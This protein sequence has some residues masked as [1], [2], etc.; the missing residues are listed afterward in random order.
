MNPKKLSLYAGLVVVGILLL[1]LGSGLRLYTDWLWFDAIGYSSV[2]FTILLSNLWLQVSVGLVAFA[3]LA[4]N[5]LLTRKT[6][7]QKAQVFLQQENVVLIEGMELPW[8]KL[9]TK[10]IL[11]WGAIA[12]SALIAFLLSLTVSSEWELLQKFLNPNSFGLADPL[13]SRDVGFY[14]FTFPFQLFLYNTIFWIGLVTTLFVGAAYYLS[15][16]YRGFQA[17]FGESFPRLHVGGL[18]T[19]LLLVKAWGYYLERHLL[20]YSERGAVFGAGW[21]DVNASLLAY[22]VL[23]VLALLAAGLIIAAA[24]TRRLQPNIL[25]YAVGGIIVA[26]IALSVVYPAVLQRFAVDPNE[27][28]RERPFL[29]ENIKFTREAYGIND[30]ERQP[31]PAGQTVDRDVI[32]ANNP[33]VDNIRLWDWEALRSSYAQLQ[34]IRTYYEFRDIDIDRYTIDG[35]Y[36]QVMLAPRELDQTQLPDQA[37]TWVNQRLVYTH[38][39]GVAMSPANEVSQEGQPL[40]LMQDIPAQVASEELRLDQ[41][42]IYFGEATDPY[43]IAPS[44]QPEFNYPRGEDN[45]F[46]NYTGGTGVKLDSWLKRI[47]FAITKADYNLLLSGD[48]TSESEL[49]MDRNIW[50]RVPKIAP[51][52]QLDDDPYVVVKDGKLYWIWDAYTTSNMFPYS[53]PAVRGGVNY[54]RNSVKVV[55]DAYTGEVEFYVSEP[56]DP[57]IQTYQ[58][59]FPEMFK[60]LDQMPQGLLEHIRYPV[61]L[62]K[63]QARIYTSYH[64][65]NPDVFYSREDQWR[66]PNEISGQEERPMEPYYVIMQ[67]PDNE[68]S[69]FVQIMPFT[70][71]GRAN[72]IGWMAG[73]SDGDNYGNLVVFEMPKDSLVYGPMQVEARVDQDEFISQQLTLWERRGSSVIRGNLLVIP[74]EDSLL[75]VEPVYLQA[76]QS[77]MPEL[78]RVILVHGDRVV[79]EPDLPSALNAMFGESGA[80]TDAPPPVPDMDPGDLDDLDLPDAPVVDQTTA[81]LIEE[82][83]LEYERAQQRLRDGDWTGYGQAIEALG[84]KLE[85]LARQSDN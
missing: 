34:Q 67:L 70:P 60:D 68:E 6:I 66:L 13:F 33:T 22:N 8:K 82:A 57:I 49:L 76:E 18:I 7:L 10:K 55:V 84:E 74:I 72:M 38:G 42:E 2:F 80:P 75:Y 83:T 51:F 69:E 39:Y 45:V 47:A 31:F 52:L 24:V 25:I 53:E 11:T 59:I 9:L 32:D 64:M 35:E 43:V 26:S 78:R 79:F 12:F 30:V 20:L 71:R 73:R 77:R 19:F 50:E 40:F 63:I 17:I 48:I 4:V 65:Q 56:D 37:Q 62:F 46:T 41:P 81:E 14:A 29:S 58:Q 36:R 44:N 23:L 1:F 61:D 54:I 15:A 16:P 27:L 28:A 5:L 3:F 85:E 21:T